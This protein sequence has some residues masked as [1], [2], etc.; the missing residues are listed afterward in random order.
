MTARL[1]PKFIKVVG[2]MRSTQHEGERTAARAKAEAMAEAAGMTLDVAMVTAELPIAQSL[3]DIFGGFD[4]WMEEREPGWKA[5]HAAE[6]D[7][8][9]QQR[10]ARRAATLKR[11]GSEEAALAPCAKEQLLHNALGARR[12]CCERPYERWTDTVDGC[13][14]YCEPAPVHVLD[15]VKNAYPMPTTF[16]VAMAE[17]RYWEARQQEIEDVLGPNNY[18]DSGLD[19]V[20]S[21]RFDMVRD[22]VE[23]ELVTTTLDDL[24]ARFK[25]YRD[26]DVACEKIDAALFR[27]LETLV[28]RTHLSD[29]STK[30]EG[31]PS[32]SSPHPTTRDGQ[33]RAALHAD[34]SRSDRAIARAIGC[35]PTSVGKTRLAM[36]LSW[37]ERSVQRRGQMCSMRPRAEAPT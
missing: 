10:L 19:L 32:P 5:R 14:N 22:L 11:F 12:E 6:K 30:G 26:M 21:M 37:A 3:S 18:G 13:W 36:G 28:R 24:Y 27:D 8:K 15:L 17:Y 2:L 35:S 7:E 29:A 16:S 25:F 20:P 31:T 9:E 1:D 23:H 33:I 34:P 4:D